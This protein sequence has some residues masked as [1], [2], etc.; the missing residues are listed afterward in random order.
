MADD[1]EAAVEL[2][3]AECDGDARAAV[4]SLILVNAYLSAEVDRLAAAISTGFTG[5]GLW[6]K[7]LLPENA[8]QR[9]GEQEQGEDGGT[10]LD[11]N[12]KPLTKRQ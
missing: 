8:E 9:S 4:R 6:R 10:L 12:A 7:A 2:A 11:A 3:I 5:G 1:L